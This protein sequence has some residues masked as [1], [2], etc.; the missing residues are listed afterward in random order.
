MPCKQRLAPYAV[1]NL[2]GR[3]YAKK[4]GP[5]E[6]VSK[7]PFRPNLC[8]GACDSILEILNVF[9]RLNR[10]LR[11]DLEPERRL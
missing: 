1:W 2:T 8:G 3:F 9:L 6:V 7:P 11:L 10:M 4:S 5:P